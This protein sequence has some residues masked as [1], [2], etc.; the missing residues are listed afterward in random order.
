MESGIAGKVVAITGASSG[1]G[2]ATALLLAAGGAKVV[3]G[4]RRA[5]KLQELAEQIAATGGEAVY[6]V[7]DVKQRADVAS[8]V[9]L[10]RERF[11][12]LDVLINNAGIG[13]T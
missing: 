9:G 10:A 4:A 13:T 6:I 8:L 11:G 2:R 1:I 5:D 12:K 3:L 7:T